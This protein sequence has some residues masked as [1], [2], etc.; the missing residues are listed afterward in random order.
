MGGGGEKMENTPNKNVGGVEPK[1]P[2][3]S[4]VPE[5]GDGTAGDMNGEPRLVRR[6]SDLVRGGASGHWESK[7]IFIIDAYRHKTTEP[8]LRPVKK[9]LYDSQFKRAES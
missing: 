2:S 4:H 8:E 7:V 9:S 3:K 5:R 6:A 1:K